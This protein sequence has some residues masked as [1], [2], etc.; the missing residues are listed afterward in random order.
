[1]IYSNCK[2]YNIAQQLYDKIYYTKNVEITALSNP[3]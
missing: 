3:I 2:I 1:M